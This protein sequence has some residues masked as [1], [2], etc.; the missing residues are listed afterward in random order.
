MASNLIVPCGRESVDWDLLTESFKNVRKD[1]GWAV[2]R[3]V[4]HKFNWGLEEDLEREHGLTLFG[5]L[6]R[7]SDF[8]VTK[9]RD[10]VFGM[11]GLVEILE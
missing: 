5:L 6:L 10:K 11:L 2:S 4:N 3:L 7:Y 9:V 1:Y 8:G